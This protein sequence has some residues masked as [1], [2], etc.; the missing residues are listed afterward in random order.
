MVERGP[1]KAGVGG[2]IPSLAT[3]IFNNL[4]VQTAKVDFMKRV[5][6]SLVLFLIG[7]PG[8]QVLRATQE[9]AY[10]GK[11][12][13]VTQLEPKLPGP[14]TS[15][16][17]GSNFEYRFR[18]VIRDRDTWHE[19]WKRVYQHNPSNGP[20]PALPEIDFSREMVI[21]AAMG[22]QPTTGYAV[23]IDGAYERNDRL[24]VIVT[25]VISSKCGGQYT[26]VT[27]PIDIVRLPKIQRPVV[28]REIEVEPDCKFQ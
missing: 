25:S 15:F 10:Q 4:A 22:Q 1:E 20:Y 6:L 24:E 26:I 28:F 5:L 12:V 21:V 17:L 27:S 18:L 23:I 3:N 14:R 11:P 9:V 16:R 19:I 2:S 7:S 8:L 13:P